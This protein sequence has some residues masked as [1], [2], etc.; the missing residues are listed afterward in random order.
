MPKELATSKVRSA[1][2]LVQHHQE[3]T[4]ELKVDIPAHGEAN[5]IC[6]TACE[7]TQK[8][9]DQLADELFKQVQQPEP[10]TVNNS[11]PSSV[12]DSG[13]EMKVQ[14]SRDTASD[15]VAIAGGEGRSSKPGFALPS[16]SESKTIVQKETESH[17]KSHS[18]RGFVEQK[19]NVLKKYVA[20][21]NEAQVSTVDTSALL[22]T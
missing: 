7:Q 2:N 16:N 8:Q 22:V 6:T 9:A 20:T 1:P 5:H 17:I 14:V 4:Q 11:E 12:S 15:G 18:I 3:S 21:K 19:I 10:N 13:N